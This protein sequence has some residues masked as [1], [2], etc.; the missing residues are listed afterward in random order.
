MAHA[1]DDRAAAMPLPL[2]SFGEKLPGAKAPFRIAAIPG[3]ERVRQA[4]R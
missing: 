2:T 1:G 4:C 3:A